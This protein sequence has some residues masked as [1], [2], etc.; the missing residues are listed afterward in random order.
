MTERD[1][2]RF[3]AF[4]R[5]VRAPML[6]IARNLCRN[7]GRDPEDLVHEGL[8]RV[9]RQLEHGEGQDPLTLR[10]VSAVMTNR[11][12]DLCRRK[13]VEESTLSAS[14]PEAG[15]EASVP[16]HEEIEQWRGVSDERLLE[17]IATLHPRR[18]REAYEMHAQGLRYRQIAD[19]LG[20]PEGTVG[21]D[22]SE[23]RKQL[24]KILLNGGH[25][26]WD[27]RD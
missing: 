24:R 6:R 15:E 1:R 23:A 9:L 2:E 20:I 4:V 13:R 27:G 22:L 19:R 11:Y 21:S 16:E 14:E 18:V 25:G 3:D 8:E 5:D 12:I 10:F 26:H 17:A 7:D